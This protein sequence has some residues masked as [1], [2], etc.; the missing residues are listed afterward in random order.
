MFTR[1]DLPIIVNKITLNAPDKF[2]RNISPKRAVKS[3]RVFTLFINN[4]PC[5]ITERVNYKI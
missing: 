1:E 5:G 2:E 3:G 4:N